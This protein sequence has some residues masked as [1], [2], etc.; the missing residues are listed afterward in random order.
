MENAS[1]IPYDSRN[2][3]EQNPLRFDY[4][5]AVV[6]Q[7]CP[8]FSGQIVIIVNLNDVCAH[9]GTQWISDCLLLHFGFKEILNRNRNIRNM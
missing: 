9:L 5:L 6:K 4:T 3:S 2:R 7:L 1:L 8:I